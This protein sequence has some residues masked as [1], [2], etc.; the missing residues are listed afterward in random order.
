MRER[1]RER[2]RETIP[3]PEG[4]TVEWRETE[5]KD[6]A[7][8]PIGRVRNDPFLEG[9]DRLI[10]HPEDQPVHNVNITVLG[11][12]ERAALFPGGGNLRV[13]GDNGESSRVDLFPLKLLTS[14]RGD[15]PFHSF[16]RGVLLGGIVHK[17]TF[18][19]FPPQ[20]PTHG[21]RQLH[22]HFSKSLSLS[23]TQHSHSLSLS[24]TVSISTH[25]S[26]SLSYPAETRS[27]RREGS[28]PPRRGPKAAMRS[29][30][31]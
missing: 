28:A 7:Y 11:E 1:E 6:S 12:R 3:V 2:G 18:P 21:N 27:L 10:D 16:H 19:G 26:L 20:I 9:H 17:D 15:N 8:V 29:R 23:L 24:V 30:E 14:E 22:E 13:L 5:A 25:L 31:I 4:P